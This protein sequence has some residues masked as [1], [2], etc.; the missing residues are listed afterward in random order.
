MR[1]LVLAAVMVMA[2]ALRAAAELRVTARGEHAP[3]RIEPARGSG[4]EGV[5][6]VDGM[7]GVELRYRP[8]SKDGKV[9]WLRFDSRG[10]A[11]ATDAGEGSRDGDEVVMEIEAGDMGY[12]A[13]ENNRRHCVWVSDYRM[14]P[15]EAHGVECVVADCAGNTIRTSGTGE[16]MTYTGITGR[17]VEIDREIWLTYMNVEYDGERDEYVQRE[18]IISLGYL[19]DEV[20]CEPTYCDTRYRLSGDRFGRAWGMASEAESER[21]EAVAVTAEVSASQLTGGNEDGMELGGS[22]PAEI[23]FSAAVSDGVV[24]TEW[25]I[26]DDESFGRIEYRY[27]D[28]EATHTFRESGRSYARFVCANGDGSCSYESEATAIE[29]GESMMKC[30]NAFSPD[31]DGVNDEWRVRSRSIVEFDCRIYDRQG[32]EVAHLTSA[33]QGWDGRRGGKKAKAGVYYYVIR[34]K[35]SDGKVYEKSGDINIIDYRRE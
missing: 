30:P 23:C 9:R 14:H 26:S 11:Y 2:V 29:I 16:R 7:S 25:Q 10:A 3:V 35:G 22:A 15:F 8:E 18:R 12:I 13:E 17:S 32:R 31:G 4:L 28:R 1:I 21:V 24:Y 19:R 33:E 27:N 5:Y 34:A 6:V 20:R